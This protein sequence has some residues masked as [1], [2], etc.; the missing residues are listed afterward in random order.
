MRPAGGRPLRIV[1]SIGSLNVGG[2]ETQLVK[3][4]RGLRERGHDVHVVALCRGGPLEADLR[5]LGVPTRVFSF[6]GF[7]RDGWDRP[8]ARPSA[9]PSARPSGTLRRRLQ[10]ARRLLHATGRLIALWWHLRTLKPDVCHAFLFTCC[11]R[12]LPLAWAAGVPVRVNGRRGASPPTPTGLV[13]RVLD[14]ASRRSSSQYVTNCHGIARELLGPGGVPADRV[15]VIPNGVELPAEAADAARCPPRG[16]VVANLI[17]Y[18]GHADIVEALALLPG[19]PRVRFVGDGP[20]RERLGALIEA[21]GLRHVVELAGAVPD[22]RTLLP[23]HQF[24][25]LA[26]H[27]EGL[28]NAVLEAMAAGLPVIV[29]AVGELPGIVTDGRDGLLVPPRDPAAL[30][31][32]IGR[33]AADPELR[34]ALGAAARRTAQRYGVGECVAR[35]EAVYRARLR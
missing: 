2:T 27:A 24:A 15:E 11:T 28:P 25:V 31:A 1:L 33:I 10:A 7:R 30:A 17:A 23:G 29:T 5:S 18:K 22:S 14:T 8:T 16:I 26:S 32:A 20:E 9:Q 12:V 19:P 34:A 13:R 4:A 6:G 21:R 3:L 35:H